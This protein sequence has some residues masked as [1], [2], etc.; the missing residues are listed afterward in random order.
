MRI[1][2]VNC[3]TILP[4]SDVVAMARAIDA[5]L[6][7][8]YLP[9]WHK[10]ASACLF[11]PGGLRY[12]RD[13]DVL[14]LRLVDECDA[15]GALGYHTEESDGSI[16]GEIG[17]KTVLDAG[18]GVL[19]AGSNGDSISAVASHESCEAKGN[20]NV[21]LWIEGPTTVEGRT[22][23]E[24]AAEDCDPCQSG[25]Y[26]K[27][28]VL[29]SEFVFPAW[30]DPGNSRGPWSFLGSVGGPLQLAPGG[31]LVARDAPGGEEDVF[32]AGVNA[33]PWRRGLRRHMVKRAR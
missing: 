17:V 19:V 3:S 2:L 4:D 15:A 14:A 6:N 10:A 5:Q 9:R 30:R 20:P 12:V 7:E 22:F 16:W 1:G 11:V 25:T 27:N 21:N 13:P 23:R 29:V 32:A 26:W 8:D 31:Y 24:V 18:G 33:R 28:G